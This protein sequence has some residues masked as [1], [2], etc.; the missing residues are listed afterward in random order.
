FNWHTRVGSF[1]F[2]G[3]GTTTNDFTI[4]PNPTSQTVAAGSSTT[5]TIQT[6]VLSGAA[7]TI[8]LSVSGLPTG[9]TGSFNPTSVTAGGTS[10]LTLT[11]ATTAPA[12]TAQFT[13]TGTGT[14]ATHNANASVTV[15]N[16]N[17]PPTVSITSPANNSTVSGTVTVNANASDS[18]GTV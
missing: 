16:N 9:V 2:A 7:Q 18:D 4:T 15:T 1:K 12:T 3:C 14:S 11:A 5:Y 13:I 10:T 6:T 8:N 17:T